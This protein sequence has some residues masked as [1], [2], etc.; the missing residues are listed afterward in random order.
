[1]EGSHWV[2]ARNWGIRSVGR[3]YNLPPTLDA[4]IAILRHSWMR[5]LLQQQVGKY[6]HFY[7][8]LIDT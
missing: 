1:M 7:F 5:L 4:N 3:H 8:M 6:S 2:L